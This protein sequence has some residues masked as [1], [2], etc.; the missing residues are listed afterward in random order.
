MLF[1]SRHTSDACHHWDVLL[2]HSVEVVFARCLCWKVTIFSFPRSSLW[3]QRESLESYFM[4]PR[5]YRHTIIVLFK[6]NQ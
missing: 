1:S 3:K 2:D 4:C 6:K 5:S